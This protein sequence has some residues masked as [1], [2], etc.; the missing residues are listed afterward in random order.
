MYNVVQ[1]QDGGN[2]GSDLMAIIELLNLDIDGLYIR[3]KSFRGTQLPQSTGLLDLLDLHGRL[4]RT[5]GQKSR[6]DQFAHFPHSK[7]ES[8]PTDRIHRKPD[9]LY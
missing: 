9:T 6:W 1:L 2:M 5:Q 4:G 8:R 7:P 3:P